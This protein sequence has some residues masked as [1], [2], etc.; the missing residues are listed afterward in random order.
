MARVCLLVGC[1][2]AMSFGTASLAAAAPGIQPAESPP[3]MTT[4]AGS[5]SSVAGPDLPDAALYA[6]LGLA[7]AAALVIAAIW[8]FKLAR[9]GTSRDR[10]LAPAEI[11][12]V[13]A[14]LMYIAGAAA[15]LVVGNFLT[16]P[17]T[18]P[19][20][21]LVVG[22]GAVISLPVIVVWMRARRYP[23]PHETDA[24][25]PTSPVASGTAI[26]I[27]LIGMLLTWPLVWLAGR[28]WTAIAML[29]GAEAPDAIAHS[30][31]KSMI[32]SPVSP[33]LIAEI[34][35][36]T[37]LV[38]VFEEIQYRGMIQSAVCA[39]PGGRPSKTTRWVAIL[40]TSLLFALM[41]A[42]VAAPH[43]LASLAVLSVG[44]GV[45]YERSGSLLAP[46]TMHV[47][48]NAGNL[49]LAWIWLR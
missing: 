26:R 49:A 36:V 27:G 39:T 7:F 2:V 19:N 20:G 41:H 21:L 16:A 48:F 47:V 44:M 23:A 30:T 8:K 3:A 6:Q 1:F 45:V 12:L 35:L 42:N 17:D 43:A 15:L 37:L 29:G 46:I 32:E 18:T 24:D 31:L 4:D 33:R 10:P 11:G 34:L 28:I 38:P 5:D 25:P 9:L 13:C 22:C 14:V 40:G